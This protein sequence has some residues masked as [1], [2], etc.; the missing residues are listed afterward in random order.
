MRISDWS[1]DVCSSDLIAAD[2]GGADLEQIVE[3]ARDHVAF[4]DLRQAAHRGVE[5]AQRV[6]ARV[7]QLDLG[8]GD[9]I[10]TD[11]GRVDDRAESDDQSAFL[12]PFD[13]LLA[14]CLGQADLL[15]ERGEGDAAILPEDGEKLAIELVQIDYR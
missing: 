3:A 14:R 15:R 11:L 12:H 5:L 13:A 4:L 7:R 9:M 2:V 8:K 6:L 10:E 1:S